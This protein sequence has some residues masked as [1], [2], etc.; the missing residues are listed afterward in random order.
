LLPRLAAADIIFPALHGKGGEDGELQKFLESHHVKYVGSGAEASARCLDKTRYAELLKKRGILLPATDTVT[1]EAYKAS[2]L[3]ERPFVLK[4]IDG[5]SSIDMFIVRDPADA[6]QAAIAAA[7]QKY[8]TLI[9]QEFVEGVEITAGVLGTEALPI[10][11]IIPPNGEYFDYENK[12]NGQTQELCP[13]E[14]VS[15]QDQAQAQA[16][17]LEIHQLTGCR[18]MSRTDI[19]I[20]EDGRQY[21]LETN[22]IPG[23]TGESLLPKAAAEAGYTMPDLCNRL[24]ELAL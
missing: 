20:D 11:E 22:T 15:K 1:L 2:P 13:P 23:L 19:I 21:V 24:I 5:G 14:H 12:Y 7:F 8:G 17:A 6:D 3:R 16:L 18:D 4:P 10:I 9:L